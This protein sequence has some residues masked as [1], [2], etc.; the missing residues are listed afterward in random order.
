MFLLLTGASGAGKSS[1]RRAIEGSLPGV[2]CVEL[3]DV[4]EI[5]PAPDLAWRQQSVEEVVQRAL[6]V[7]HL[8]LAGDPVAPGEV[9]AAPSFE[10]LDGFAAC[11]LDC[12][13]AVQR[14]RLTRRGDQ[15][16]WLDHHVAF[17]AWMRGHVRDPGYRPEVIQG[18]GWEEMRW[19]RWPA[20]W[21]FEEIDTSE[22]SV[23]EVAAEVERWCRG[24]LG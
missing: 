3:R 17:A 12:S 23:A 6:T 22:L 4:V 11:L 13:E 2:D 7:E 8:L 16:A 19:E 21:S 5:P 18:A 9:L 15:V 20:A 1:V 24:V 14:E 10:G